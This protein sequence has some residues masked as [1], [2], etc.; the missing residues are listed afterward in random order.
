MIHYGEKGGI[1]R[2]RIRTHHAHLREGVRAFPAEEY[3][4]LQRH[5]VLL[6]A[7]DRIDHFQYLPTIISLLLD[8]D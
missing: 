2:S 8:S 1:I 6:Y 3:G 5:D 7:W 4:D